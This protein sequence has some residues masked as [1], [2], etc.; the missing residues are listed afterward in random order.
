MDRCSV[1]FEE[2]TQFLYTIHMTFGF[3]GLTVSSSTKCDLGQGELI[4]TLD[5][6]K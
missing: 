3:R 5:N 6:S 2:E 1:S 4:Y